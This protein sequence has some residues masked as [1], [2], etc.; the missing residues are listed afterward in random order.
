MPYWMLICGVPRS[1]GTNAVPPLRLAMNLAVLG[2]ICIMPSAPFAEVLSE[3]FDS[4]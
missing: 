3:N 1:L 2:R 4:W